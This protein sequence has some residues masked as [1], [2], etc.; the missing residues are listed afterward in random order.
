[1]AT[2]KTN[3]P[4]QDAPNYCANPACNCKVKPG[5]QYCSASC[6]KELNGGPC[7]CGHLD[8]QLEQEEDS[9]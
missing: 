2:V 9:L 8:C 3:L 7:V 1:M 5:D 4:D 6:E